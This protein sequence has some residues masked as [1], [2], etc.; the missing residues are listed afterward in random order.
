MNQNAEIRIEDRAGPGLAEN[1]MSGS[2]RVTSLNWDFVGFPG[3]ARRQ[4]LSVRHR[5]FR[6]NGF[7][8]RHIGNVMLNVQ[9]RWAGQLTTV[10][11]T[12]GNPRFAAVSVASR[13]ADRSGRRNPWPS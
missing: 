8:G 10:A 12:T 6:G 2:V 7:L 11:P 13:L 4:D 3:L 1:M 9:K 5:P